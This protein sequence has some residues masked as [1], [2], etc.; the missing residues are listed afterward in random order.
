MKIN[1]NSIRAGN[2]LEHNGRLCVVTRTPDHTMPG[3]G[4]AFVQVEMKD[5]KTGTKITER[6][7]SSED[8]ERVRLDQKEYQF[9]FLD[10]NHLN[11]MD[12]ETFEQIMI[13]KELIGEKLAYLQDGMIIIVELYEDTPIKISVPDTVVLRVAETEPVI[14]GQTAA[15]SYKP[16]ILENGMR[17]MV[18]PFIDPDTKI[19]VKTEDDSYVE[20]YKS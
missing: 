18:P 20:R 2:V 4:G 10:D 7:R 16:A 9:L 19:V 3:K 12:T 5:I 6:F 15:S 14:K 11:L 1:A 13:D 8:V 17:I